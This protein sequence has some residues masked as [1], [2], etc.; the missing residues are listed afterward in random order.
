LINR[1]MKLDQGIEAMNLASRPG[2]LK[3]TLMMD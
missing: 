3:V 2:V 1:R